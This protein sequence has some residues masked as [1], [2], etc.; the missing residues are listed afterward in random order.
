[1]LAVRPHALR[2]HKPTRTDN[3]AGDDNEYEVQSILE[4]R[5]SDQ[6]L[7]YRVKWLGFKYDRT[8]YNAGNFKNSPYKLRFPL[9]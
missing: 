7:Q 1:M 5:M 6:K 8:W 9:G 3:T 2:K 4:A